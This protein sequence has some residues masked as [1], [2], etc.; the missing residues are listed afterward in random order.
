[1]PGQRSRLVDGTERRDLLHDRASAAERPDRHA[2]AD[3]LA[4]RGQVRR[5]VEEALRAP[6]VHAK[7]RHH[8]IEDQHRSVAIA[9]RAQP[10]QEIAARHHEVHVA[11]DWLD[12]DAGDARAVDLERGLER[13]EIVVGKH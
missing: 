6:R 9:D 8:F 1:L 10:A 11:R 7:T 5:H 2:A 13:I 4:E 12:D 3:H